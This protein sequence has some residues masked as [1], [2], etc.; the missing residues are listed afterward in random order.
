MIY[1]LE[2]TKI[3]NIPLEFYE[4]LHNQKVG[5]KTDKYYIFP[6]MMVHSNSEAAMVY[7]MLVQQIQMIGSNTLMITYENSK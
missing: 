7:N 1:Q 2:H 5:K 3:K 4:M 6:A